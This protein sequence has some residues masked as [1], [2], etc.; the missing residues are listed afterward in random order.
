[1]PLPS[2]ILHHFRVIWHSIRFDVLIDVLLKQHRWGKSGCSRM[3]AGCTVLFVKEAALGLGCLDLCWACPFLLR[4]LQDF[5]KKT[6]PLLTRPL[7]GG[8]S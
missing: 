7:V 1:M 6:T 8:D 3:E 5:G 4:R 2:L